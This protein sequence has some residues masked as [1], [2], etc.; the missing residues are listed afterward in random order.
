MNK[1]KNSIKEQIYRYLNDIYGTAR[2]ME[3]TGQ[4]GTRG[5]Q[6]ESINFRI[7]M[8]KELLD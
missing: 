5:M 1:V 3:K 8:I 6:V 2:E 7:E 4:P